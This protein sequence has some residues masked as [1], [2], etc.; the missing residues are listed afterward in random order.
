MSLY[1]K[2]Q[3]LLGVGGG[4]MFR[5]AIPPVNTVRF[6]PG[7]YM[8]LQQSTYDPI[9]DSNPSGL[10]DSFH[11]GSGTWPA[12]NVD[13][14]RIAAMRAL[15]GPSVG[16]M[17]VDLKKYLRYWEGPTEGDYS[18]AYAM[19]DDYLEMC[20][21]GSDPA[22]HLFLTPWPVVF[23]NT[24][25]NIFPEYYVLNTDYYQT[26][27]TS[28]PQSGYI[29]R[30]WD[31]A[32]MDKI[33]A[34]YT[35]VCERYE[36]ETYFQGFTTTETATSFVSTPP[37]YSAAAMLT[38]FKR[39]VD[40]YRAAS[41]TMLIVGGNYLGSNSQTLELIEYC[42][43]NRCAIGGPDT[44]GIDWINDGTRSL[45]F[46]RLYR[47]ESYDGSAPGTDYRGT[48]IWKNEVQSPEIGG[49]MT[50]EPDEHDPFECADLY[51]TAYNIN[52]AGYMIW[53]YNYFYGGSDQK[54]STGQS[55]FIQ[56]NP[57]MRTHNPYA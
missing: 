18:R 13:S 30:L 28:N 21:G 25:S 35:A 52:Q 4:G 2:S 6:D 48:M 12:R 46:D 57:S 39:C 37:G 3:Q 49:Y 1:L 19:I 11:S 45:Q 9:S 38:Q 36:N 31:S 33:N 27:N 43:S 34:L 55:P 16:F 24:T 29:A 23:S 15:G 22:M 10:R 5:T 17:G 42:R 41:N 54:F 7:H 51:N 47:G 26:G 20:T 56:A 53:E 8:G 50:D 32:G 40:A 44:W 14:A